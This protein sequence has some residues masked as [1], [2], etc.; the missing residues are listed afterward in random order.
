MNSIC[1]I[2]RCLDSTTWANIAHTFGEFVLDHKSMQV[3]NSNFPYCIHVLAVFR[4]HDTNQNLSKTPRKRVP[5]N[6]EGTK[7]QVSHVFPGVCH[8]WLPHAM[9]GLFMVNLCQK[10]SYKPAQTVV[11]IVIY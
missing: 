4:S 2:Y 10:V 7:G 8:R 3:T 6:L 5:P 1:T 11:L 9:A